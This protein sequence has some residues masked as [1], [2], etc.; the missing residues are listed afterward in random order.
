[1][2]FWDALFRTRASDWT[3]LELDAA[4]TPS[5]VA[6][7]AIQPNAAYLTLTLRSLRIVDVRKGLSRFFGMVHSWAS[8]PHQGSGRAEFQ[9]VTTPGELKNADAKHLDRVIPMEHPLLGPVPYRGG[10][11][12]LELGLFSVKAADLLGP[13]VDVLEG[14]SKAAGV[15]FVSAALPFVAPLKQGI[16][17]LTGSSGHSI[18]EIGIAKEWQPTTGYY[19]IVRAARG[20]INL[21]AVR[22]AAD[23]RLVDS[24]GNAIANYPY[25]VFSVEATRDRP[26]WFEIPELKQAHDELNAEVRRGRQ[27]DAEEAFAAFR[28]AALTSPDLLLEDARTICAQVKAQLAEVLPAIQTGHAAQRSLPELKTLAPFPT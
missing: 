22:V 5:G 8:I 14:M 27:T 20:D 10:N 1:V 21:S 13:F 4:Q 7:Q 19:A 18:L 28:R 12:S 3:Y 25:L 17:L 2:R 26:N 9:V 24:D 23:Q 6:H 16:E 15:T 11:L